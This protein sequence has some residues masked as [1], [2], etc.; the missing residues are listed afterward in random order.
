MDY[1]SIIAQ[2]DLLIA[3]QSGKIATLEARLAELSRLIFGAKSERFVPLSISVN[4]LSLFDV[5]ESQTEVEEPQKKQITYERTKSGKMHS[6]RNEIPEHFPVEEII[7]EP[8]EDTFEM[9]R[10]GEEI[11]EYVEYTSGSLKK[12]KIIRPKYVSKS[13]DRSVA[14][15]PLPERAFPKSIAGMTLVAWIMSRKFVEHMPFYHQIQSIKREYDWV[16]PS[17]TFNDWFA[18]TSKMLEPLYNRLK[19]KIGKRI[20]T[21]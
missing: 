12:I 17:S 9:I 2:K 6:G 3:E 5:G 13:E 8:E 19:Q 11:T 15:A 16:I 7:I 14:I 1:S 21:G 18:T 10:I 20:Y 4:Q